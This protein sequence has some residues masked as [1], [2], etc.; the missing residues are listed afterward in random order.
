MLHSAADASCNR[1]KKGTNPKDWHHSTT[2]GYGMAGVLASAA[3][4]VGALSA[5]SSLR[6]DLASKTYNN[7]KDYGRSTDLAC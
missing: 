2:G 5:A 4:M 7:H 3:C 6:G 1:V